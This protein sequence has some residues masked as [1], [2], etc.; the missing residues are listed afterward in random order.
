[1][2]SMRIQ[3][4]SIL[5]DLLYENIVVIDLIGMLFIYCWNYGRFLF[6]LIHFYQVFLLKFTDYFELKD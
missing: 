2:I 5:D 4:L 1:M 6:K 3:W